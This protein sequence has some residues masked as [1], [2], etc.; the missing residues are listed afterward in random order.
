MEA[1]TRAL[2]RVRVC[3]PPQLFHLNARHVAG[4]T[5]TEANNNAGMAITIKLSR[6]L[7]R[8]YAA[9]IGLIVIN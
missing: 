2:F 5:S 3:I 4:S 8:R 9:K 6:Q 1:L 7:K